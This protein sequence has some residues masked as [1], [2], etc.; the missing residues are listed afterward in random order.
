QLSKDASFDIGAR[1]II[2]GFLPNS[3]QPPPFGSVNAG[4]VSLA[5]HYLSRSNEFYVVYGDPNSLATTPALFVKW[6]RYVGAT[7]GT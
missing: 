6:I 4:N 3:F 2:G 7:K 1:R 5:F